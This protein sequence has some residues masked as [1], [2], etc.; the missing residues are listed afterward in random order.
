[1][2]EFIGNPQ[3]AIRKAQEVRFDRVHRTRHAAGTAAQEVLRGVSLA[4]PA[5][6]SV[7]V[8]GRSGGGK[9]TLLRLL[10]RLE[11]PDQGA[12]FYGGQD[13]RA[14]D[15]IALRRRIALVNQRSV[16]FPGSVLDNIMLPDALT[17][18]GPGDPERARRALARVRLEAEL[19][20]RDAAALSVGQQGRVQ[21]ARSLYLDPEVVL[22]DESTANLDPK[23]AYEILDELHRWAADEGR[24]LIHISHEP[25]KLRRCARLILLDEG[26]VTADGDAA[27]VLDDPRS[28]AAKILASGGE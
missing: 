7:G 12:I 27:A 13:L 26:R 20:P 9:T 10:T 25:D 19:A 2:P 18:R 16:M 3:S 11:D 5:G 6:Q 21:L 1:M 17:G 15:V 24:T 28:P 22:L 4:I 23:V 14:L 8:I